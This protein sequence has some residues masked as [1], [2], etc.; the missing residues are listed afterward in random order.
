MIQ[1]PS[2]QHFTIIEYRGFHDV[3]RFILAKDES[4]TYWVLA[5]PFD[6]ATDEYSE[7]YTIFESGQD[8]T[9]ARTVL[10]QHCSGKIVAPT[11]TLSVVRIEFDTTKRASFYVAGPTS[12]EPLK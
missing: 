2:H 10:Y 3:P 7:N 11:C 6:D 5:S 4:G 8:E 1:F 12:D 9:R